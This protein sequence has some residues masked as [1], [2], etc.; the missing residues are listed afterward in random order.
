MN[1][2]F[3]STFQPKINDLMERT[4][5]F[6]TYLDYTLEREQTQTEHN[7]VFVH[8]GQGDLNLNGNGHSLRKGAL[9]Y[10]PRGSSFR[11]VS[12]REHVLK[13][14]SIYITYGHLCW[15]GET[16][17]WKENGNALLPIAPFAM[18]DD[19]P[20]VMEA[21]YRLSDIWTGKRP[22]Y[23]WYSRL[24]LIRLLDLIMQAAHEA[25]PQAKQTAMLI[26]AAIDFI[27]NHLQ[28]DLNRNGLA[29]R[30]FLSPAY[31][32][33]MFKKHVGLS[34]NEFIIN[35]RM[36]EARKLL[37]DT[38]FPIRYIAAKVGYNDPFYFTRTFKKQHG[39]SPRQFRKI[40]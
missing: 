22:G 3:L 37:S 14:F 30:F 1:W 21:F 36:E 31:F 25:S 35:L 8:E 16:A 9:I 34:L 2:E 33:S 11:I 4:P 27:R 29:A 13:F 7:L 23:E 12:S 38:D 15:E 32:A 24:E 17:A 6:W 28:D 26:E 40:K 10:I 20:K 19:Q 5:S 39:M 18:L